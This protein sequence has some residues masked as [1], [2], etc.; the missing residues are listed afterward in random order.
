VALHAVRNLGKGYLEQ[1]LTLI[2]QLELEMSLH[3]LEL[4]DTM[5]QPID[6]LAAKRSRN[7]ILSLDAPSSFG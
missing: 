4:R 2:H 6:C 7:L 5:G 3:Q 1:A